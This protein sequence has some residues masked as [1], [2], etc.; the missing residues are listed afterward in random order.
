MGSSLRKLHACIIENTRVE[1]VHISLLSL[2]LSSI[3]VKTTKSSRPPTPSFDQK[4]QIF[5]PKNQKVTT[6]LL[7]M[8]FMKHAHYL[9]SLK[10]CP[11]TL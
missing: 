11:L 5:L 3:D 2:S 9:S 7:Y 8:Y 1:F 4:Y 10:P 6:P